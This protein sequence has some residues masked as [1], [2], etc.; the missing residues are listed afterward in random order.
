MAKRWVLKAFMN[1]VFDCEFLMSCGSL[2][3]IMGPVYE[4][5]FW[6]KVSVLTEGR[7]RM[8]LSLD[9]WG[10][11]D[12]VYIFLQDFGHTPST[13][14]LPDR[15]PTNLPSLVPTSPPRPSGECRYPALMPKVWFEW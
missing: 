9:E 1:E 5:D 3:Q 8:W 4:K 12:G 7:R 15:Y 6:P 2:F 10:C 13:P 14:T 11:L